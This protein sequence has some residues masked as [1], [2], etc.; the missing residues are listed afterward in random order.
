MDSFLSRRSGIDPKVLRQ[1]FGCAVIAD[2]QQ[3]RSKIDDISLSMTA[4]A[5]VPL[6]H[7]QTGSVIIMKRTPG[8]SGVAYFQAILFSSIPA[9][10]TC[11]QRLKIA[12]DISPFL[13]VMKLPS[14][15]TSQKK[16]I[17][18]LVPGF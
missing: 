12:N 5:V 4:K 14:I 17:S 6:I 15:T 3:S 16:E 11:L 8:H 9:G 2:T 7:L 13:F 1:L 18:G 10:D